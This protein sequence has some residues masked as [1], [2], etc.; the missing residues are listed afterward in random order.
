[1]RN[2]DVYSDLRTLSLLCNCGDNELVK[3]FDLTLTQFYALQHIATRPGLR[4]IDLSARLL[5]E[6]STV[7]H[8]V[9]EFVD[10]GLVDRIPDTHD[11]RVQRVR[12]TPKG[13]EKWN[14]IYTIFETSIEARFRVFSPDEL[15]IL[16]RFASRLKEH[17]AK[18][19][20]VDLEDG[21]SD[22]N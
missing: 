11:R 19:L 12:L 17:L 4:Q 5:V 1:M 10:A 13:Y 20:H 22:D 9:D 8:V 18:T 2:I 7:T 15:Y 14:H 3:T 16:G 6:R 21:A